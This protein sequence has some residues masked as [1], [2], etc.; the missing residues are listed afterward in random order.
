[1]GN[2]PAAVAEGARR[3]TGATAAYAAAD[4]PKLANSLAT[5]GTGRQAQGAELIGANVYGPV[6]NNTTPCDCKGLR[7]I[8][9]R[10]LEPLSPG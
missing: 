6:Q 7:A 10:G 5:A 3:A 9:P 1:M 8:P 4:Q 2:V